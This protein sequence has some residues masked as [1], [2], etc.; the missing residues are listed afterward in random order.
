MKKRLLKILIS[1]YII[2]AGSGTTLLSAQ[3]QS[4]IPP[5]FDC[6]SVDIGFNYICTSPDW[7]QPIC[8]GFSASV[9]CA[10]IAGL[11]GFSGG[12]A[13]SSCTWWNPPLTCGDYG[14]G[15]WSFSCEFF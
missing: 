15:G 8:E 1:C 14:G 2:A 9:A 11:C 10:Y 7:D 4:S 3:Q 13:Q 12:T 6:E 5:N